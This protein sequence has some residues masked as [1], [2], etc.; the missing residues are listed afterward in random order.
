[1]LV[2]VSNLWCLLSCL[3]GELG[4]GGV[5]SVDSIRYFGHKY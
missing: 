5:A 4:T 1:M 3:N 2:W